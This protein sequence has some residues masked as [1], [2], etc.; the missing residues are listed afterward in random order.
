MSQPSI[1]LLALIQSEL[2][3]RLPSICKIMNIVFQRYITYLNMF[4][5]GSL[6][7]RSSLQVSRRLARRLIKDLSQGHHGYARLTVQAYTYLLNDA[8]T[9]KVGMYAPELVTAAPHTK[10]RGLW[11]TVCCG[12]GSWAPRTHLGSVIGVL[13]THPASEIRLLGVDLLIQFL[14]LQTTSECLAQLEGFVP[15]VCRDAASV[16]GQQED[17]E[18]ERLQAA[19]LRALLEHLRL[20]SR[21]SF[22]SQNLSAIESAMLETM[23]SS[24]VTM[25]ETT[26]YQRAVVAGAVNYQ[27]TRKLSVGEK[28]EG[29]PPGIAAKIVFEE[30]TK[31]T[32]DSA[33]G[34]RV[35][36]ILLRFLN[37]RERWL[38]LEQ[39]GV[40]KVAMNIIRNACEKEH[41]RFTLYSAL[42]EHASSPGLTDAERAVIVQL[43]AH[44][45]QLL[46]A[47]LM[48]P[49]LRLALYN[50]PVKKGEPG[51]TLSAAVSEAIS[52]LTIQ[53]QDP[54]QVLEAIVASVA[55]TRGSPESCL[56]CCIVAATN[57]EQLANHVAI[58]PQQLLKTLAG[59]IGNGPTPA[60]RAYSAQLLTLIFRKVGKEPREKQVQILLSE[61]MLFTKHDDNNPLAFASVSQCIRAANAQRHPFVQKFSCS[62]QNQ[63]LKLEDLSPC[64]KYAGLLL[65][66]SAHGKT[67]NLKALKSLAPSSQGLK[68]LSDDFDQED[69]ET[70]VGTLQDMSGRFNEKNGFIPLRTNPWQVEVG[71][72]AWVER[73]KEAANLLETSN[74]LESASTLNSGKEHLDEGNSMIMMSDVDDVLQAI[75]AAIQG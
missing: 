13:L 45:G 41:Q 72:A 6:S 39:N 3:R 5:F 23:E 52:K 17:F 7:H 1:N 2:L 50:F 54:T 75:S 42:V 69:E 64:Q 22:V 8:G 66:E 36:E 71:G 70:V 58:F 68:A 37:S 11:E 43:A 12:A 4:G 29:S 14:K 34:R 33:E 53:I 31:M 63:V 44:E 18:Q 47:P 65:A 26:A 10:R 62:L 49:A 9:V 24:P 21:L 27:L 35:I 73:L 46:E 28:A 57:I 25:K 38:T 40:A 30:I 74:E 56:Q 15:I 16:D 55:M 59:I 67:S 61:V 48:A 32:R 20:C 60:A 19:A 51:E